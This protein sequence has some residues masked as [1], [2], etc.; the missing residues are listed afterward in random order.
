MDIVY[1]SD[2]NYADILGVSLVSL[3]ESNKG[4]ALSVHILDDGIGSENKARLL[5][6]GE[7]YRQDISFYDVT[8]YFKSELDP[9]HLT[10]STFS[11]LYMG[12]ILNE[13]VDRVLYLDCDIMIRKNLRR[14]WSADLTGLYAAAVSDCLSASHRTAIGL[15]SSSI[16]FN[17]GV[18]LVNLGLWRQDRLPKEFV[19]FTEK[20]GGNVLYADQGILNGVMSGKTK[21]LPPEYNCYTLLFDFSYDDLLI[22]RKPSKFYSRQQV[23]A[24]VSDPAIVHF[25]ANILSLRPWEKGCDHPYA[26]EW[27]SYKAMSP[28][29]DTPLRQD[30]RKLWRKAAARLYRLVPGKILLYTAGFLNTVVKP[31]MYTAFFHKK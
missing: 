2:D 5:S 6:L 10:M 15:G 7:K 17:A 23:T 13:A 11:R 18:L 26:G 21:L 24:A 19:H 4:E 27:L 31:F 3:F 16:Y 12:S 30:N 25:T 20:Y 28:W 8:R 14:L 1:A 29:A 22:Y 9:H